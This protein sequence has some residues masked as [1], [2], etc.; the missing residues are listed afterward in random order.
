MPANHSAL[1][2]GDPW[3]SAAGCRQAMRCLFII[4]R[5]VDIYSSFCTFIAVCFSTF[6]DE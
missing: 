4:S 3:G 6:N 5:F 2:A 1:P